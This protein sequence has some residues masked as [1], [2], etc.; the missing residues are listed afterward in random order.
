[1]PEP[2]RI[3]L[4]LLLSLLSAFSFAQLPKGDRI[5]AFQ[6][7]MA[8]DGDYDAA[9]SFAQEACMEAI[10]FFITWDVLEPNEGEFDEQILD[11]LLSLANIYYSAFGTKVELQLAPVN[12]NVLTV[13]EDLQSTSFASAQMIDRFKTVL[14]TVFSRMPDVELAALN[15][16]NESDIYF[17]VEQQQYVAYQTFLEAVRP[18]A[19]SKYMALHGKALKVGTT[20]TH[21]ALVDNQKASLC[22]M[23]NSNMDIIA[24]TY[25]PL[26]SDFTMQ[27][28]SVVAED[29]DQLVDQYSNTEQPIY[30]VECGYASSSIC[31]S[32]EDQQADFFSEVFKAWDEHANRIQY[33]TI[34]KSTD[35]SQE[36]VDNFE[37]YYG[38]SDLRF[39]EYLRT[40][41]LRT[42]AGSGMNKLAYERLLCELESRGFCATACRTTTVQNDLMNEQINIF[43]NPVADHLFIQ[44]PAPQINRLTL[45]DAQAHLLYATSKS[46]S[47]AMDNLAGGIYWLEIITDRGKIL[48]E[49]IIKK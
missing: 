33:L 13:P 17:G 9:F 25:Y 44:Y 21:H 5:L 42:Y 8:E 16:G 6:V 24:V 29:F 4:A 11:E 27:S 34:F 22:Q 40:L 39:K 12:T 37:L 7:D 19:Q 45:Y 35:W 10:H 48:V 23:V 41:G 28:T 31:N 49:K 14:D 20:F 46:N 32:S 36:E 3:F 2:M 43:P 1:N 15:I 18:Y 38:I 30:F 26:N 47:L